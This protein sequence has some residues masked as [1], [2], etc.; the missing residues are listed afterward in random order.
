MG[1]PAFWDNNERAQ[2]HIAKLNGL[3]K[4]VQPVVAFQKKVEAMLAAD[5]R[6][7]DTSSGERG[8]MRKLVGNMQ[9]Q[10]LML[11]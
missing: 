10:E 7:Q 11:K 9:L 2:K 6:K 4:Q 5:A 8:S 3:K 1:A